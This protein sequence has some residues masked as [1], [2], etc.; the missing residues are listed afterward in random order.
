MLVNAYVAVLIFWKVKL[1]HSYNI[2]IVED[3]VFE[4]FR[5]DKFELESGE[6]GRD[7]VPFNISFVLFGVIAEQNSII[8]DFNEDGAHFE[9]KHLVHGVFISIVYCW[10]HPWKQ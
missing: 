7:G 6:N 1:Y 8:V 3:G 2:V 9:M 4:V 10:V 5:V